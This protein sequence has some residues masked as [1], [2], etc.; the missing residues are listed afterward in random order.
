MNGWLDTSEIPRDLNF[1]TAVCSAQ[2][3]MVFLLL[4][5]LPARGNFLPSTGCCQISWPMLLLSMWPSPFRGENLGGNFSFWR[6][7]P[8]VAGLMHWC[9]FQE[10]LDVLSPPLVEEVICRFLFCFGGGYSIWLAWLS[11]RVTGR[12]NNLIWDIELYS[13]LLDFL[14][15]FLIC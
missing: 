10:L 4:P 12:L 15:N 2:V 1:S 11:G 13:W 9:I 7:G 8:V 5:Q 3:H 14:S 6:P